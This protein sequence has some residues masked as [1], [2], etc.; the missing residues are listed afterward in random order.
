MS[1]VW[2]PLQAL[3]DAA[4]GVCP[5]CDGE[6][7]VMPSPTAPFHAYRQC[8]TCNGTGKVDHGPESIKVSDTPGVTATCAHERYLYKNHGAMRV[9]EDC[10]AWQGLDDT[11]HLTPRADTATESSPCCADVQVGVLADAGDTHNEASG[12]QE[13][14]FPKEGNFPETGNIPYDEQRRMLDEFICQESLGGVMLFI[15]SNWDTIVRA[16]RDRHHSG[17]L[18][19]GSRAYGWD[20]YERRENAIEEVADCLVYLSSGKI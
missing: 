4:R 2:P 6:G 15:Y 5:Q 17:Y 14:T 7:D 19:Y 16:A 9:C 11:W 12:V 1:E 10:G 13:N 20:E 18:D 3:M 8:P